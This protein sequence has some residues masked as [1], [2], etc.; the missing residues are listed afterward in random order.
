MAGPTRYQRVTTP[1]DYD[2]VGH[3]HYLKFDGVDDFLVTGAINFTST[4]KMTVWTGVTKLS[5]AAVGALVELS[6]NP[7][8]NNGAFRLTT[9]NPANTYEFTSRGTLGPNA[10]L[11]TA[12]FIPPVSNVVTGIADIAGDLVRLRVNSVSMTAN[13]ADQGT[14]TFG[15]Y[16]IYIGRRGGT[17]FPF[18]GQLNSLAIRGAASTDNQIK[19]AERYVA[20]KTGVVLP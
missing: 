17:T 10:S 2:T 6:A 3:S 12:T 13:T 9:G 8:A 5:D 11:S 4:D 1:T 15:N 7:N 18:N 16:P 14:G 20:S 19:E